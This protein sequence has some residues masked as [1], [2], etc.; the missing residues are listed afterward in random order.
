MSQFFPTLGDALSPTRRYFAAGEL[1]ILN[2]YFTVNLGSG[3]VFVPVLR[4]MA[5]MS[6]TPVVRRSDG[7]TGLHRFTF[8]PSNAGSSATV[9]IV[10]AA[11]SPSLVNASYASG[12]NG[13]NLLP[14]VYMVGTNTDPIWLDA[15]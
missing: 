7:T 5:P 8:Y 1:V 13:G 12:D 4:G 3:G 15:S 11:V 9:N 2:P 6:K 14:S 10:L